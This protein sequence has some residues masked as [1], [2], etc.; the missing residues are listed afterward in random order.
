M[1][2]LGGH[3]AIAGICTLSLESRFSIGLFGQPT[4]ASSLVDQS[5]RSSTSLSVTVITSPSMSM[6]PKN[7]RPSLGGRFLSLL[8]A[9]R[10]DV[11]DLRTEGV[12]Q[13]VGPECAGMHRARHELPER[14]EILEHRFVG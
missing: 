14:L 5:A 6:R 11:A 4:L 2:E 10:L 12:V 8:L 3:P 7:C 13:L 1:S 9:W